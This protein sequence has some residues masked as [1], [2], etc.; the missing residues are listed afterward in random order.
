M[1]YGCIRDLHSTATLLKVLILKKKNSSTSKP[2]ISR[3][4]KKI[5]KLMC[6][7]LGLKIITEKTRPL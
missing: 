1:D 7:A 6:T 5:M 2:D 4:K 3:K